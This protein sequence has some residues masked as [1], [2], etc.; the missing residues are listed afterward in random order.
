[1]LPDWKLPAV[2]YQALLTFEAVQVSQFGQCPG[3]RLPDQDVNEQTAS[4]HEHLG[5]RIYC[6]PSR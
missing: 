5:S 6:Q 1:M 2:E 4:L 3:H